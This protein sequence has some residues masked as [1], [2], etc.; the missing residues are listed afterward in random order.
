LTCSPGGSR[1][2]ALTL[3]PS[4]LRA[5]ASRSTECHGTG[6][7]RSVATMPEEL[8]EDMKDLPQSST[9]GRSSIS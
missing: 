5:P 2:A 3:R 4:G 7:E 8:R 1:P 6:P 9:T